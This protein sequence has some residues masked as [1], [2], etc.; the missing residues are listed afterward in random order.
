[1]AVIAL[2]AA[3]SLSNPF[4]FDD[5]H[6]IVNNADLSHLDLSLPRRLLNP[7]G[8]V[9]VLERNDPSRPLVALIHTLIYHE[10]QL[11][12]RAYRACNIA[13]HLINVF[14]VYLLGLGVFRRLRQ[15][16]AQRQSLA[17]LSTSALFG[18][19]PINMGTAIY[20]YAVSDLLATT[21]TLCVLLLL[22]HGRTPTLW[23]NLL[24]MIATLMSLCA[25]QSAAAIP[26]LVAFTQMAL[27]GADDR[28]W[29]QRWKLAASSWPLWLIVLGYLGWRLWYFGELGDVEGDKLRK[30]V[31]DY[32]QVEPWAILRYIQLTFVPY[33]L[34]LDHDVINS[35]LA[36]ATK[37]VSAM[38]LM[39]AAGWS[40][41]VFARSGSPMRRLLAWSLLFSLLALAPTSSFIPTIDYLVERR[42][43]LPSAA[44]FLAAGALLFLLRKG[45]KPMIAAAI[46][47]ML[48]L[49]LYLS[50]QRIEAFGDERRLWEDVLAIYP[51]NPR[52]LTTLGAL[53]FMHNDLAGAKQKFLSALS[54]QPDS[55]I[56]LY[57]LGTIAM[58]EA[59]PFYDPAAAQKYLLEA[60]RLR[61]DFAV[62]IMMLARLSQKMGHQ[63]EAESYYRQALQLRPDYFPPYHELGS[64]LLQL[65]R[66]AEAETL[67]RSAHRLVTAID[68]PP[69]AGDQREAKRITELNLALALRLQGQIPEAA[70]LY[71]ALLRDKPDDAICMTRLAILLADRASPLF[72]ANQALTFY[73]RSLELQPNDA[74]TLKGLALLHSMLGQAEEA[75]QIRTR[76]QTLG[77]SCP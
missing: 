40:L 28:S 8:P 77:I 75:S 21:G 15:G 1:M 10:A 20:I 56:T 29:R 14:L 60:V 30:S 23:R 25:K 51:H 18:M 72:D 32:I 48:G 62:S 34:S 43:Y 44:W 67:L 41:L 9:M 70:Q 57:N 26:L 52:A 66:P 31:I 46:V 7:N 38:L 69:A 36:V 3:G 64:L 59:T 68:F 16:D 63:G 5:L 11:D 74:D 33:G 12:P 22:A 13:L 61:P 42:A 47:L 58:M 49:D 55:F 65:G 27:D 39:G 73:K 4:V 76:C 2:V 35:T 71:R 24:A 45:A 19:A 54:A 53:C 50:R 6:R 17:A 37:I